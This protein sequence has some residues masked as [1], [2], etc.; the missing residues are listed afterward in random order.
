MELLRFFPSPNPDGRPR[1]LW[2]T[3]MWPDET[4]THLGNFT[5]SQADS[6]LGLGVAVDVL[7][8]RGTVNAL[9]YAG[10]LPEVR[11][12]A[13]DPRY[14]LIHVHYGHAAAIAVAARTKPLLISF[15]GGDLLG[16]PGRNGRNTLKTTMECALFRQLPRFAAATITKSAEMDTQLPRSLRPKNHVLPNGVDMQLFHR[17]VSRPEAK[18]SVGWDPDAKVAMF[19]GNPDDPRKRVE[20]AREAMRIV[21]T[22]M[23]TARLEILFRRSPDEIPAYMHAADCLVFPSRSEGSPNTVKEAMAAALPVVAT[24]VGDIPQLCDGVA[25]CFVRPP[26]PEAFAEAL[27]QALEM[28]EAPAARKAVEPLSM[29]RIAMR[30]R[31]IYDEVATQRRGG[32]L[33]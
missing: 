29:P 20:L 26:E 27:A 7:Y 28:D 15:C 31:D 19:L 9:A 14:D 17:K 2:I 10:A 6:L 5:K 24:P 22:K 25:G 33:N 1:V 12:K 18:R 23:P 30:L 32:V 11:R 21:E 16:I 13:G 8:I 4:Q 3:A